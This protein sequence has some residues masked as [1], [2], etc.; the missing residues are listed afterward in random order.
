M[1]STQRNLLKERWIEKA[2][3]KAQLFRIGGYVLIVIYCIYIIDKMY[4]HYSCNWKHLILHLLMTTTVI[5]L[6]W[7][8]VDDT[9][10]VPSNSSSSY[11]GHFAFIGYFIYTKWITDKL[12]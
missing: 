7:N 2:L 10:P 4:Y 5:F 6:I 8:T 3:R 11:I 1:T 12:K 9:Y